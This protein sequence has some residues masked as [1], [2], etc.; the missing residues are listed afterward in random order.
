MQNLLRVQ[1]LI[2]TAIRAVMIL[3][4]RHFQRTDVVFIVTYFFDG[5]V[6]ADVREVLGVRGDVFL[7]SG[8]GKIVY[9]DV[10]S[11]EPAE[12]RQKRW[13]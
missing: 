8:H 13:D 11:T 9:E 10:Q 12:T 5:N 3:L 7:Q 6:L 4:V 2:Y 1:D